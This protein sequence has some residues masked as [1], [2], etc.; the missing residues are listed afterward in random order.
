MRLDV[1]TFPQPSLLLC[2]REP[3]TPKHTRFVRPRAAQTVATV[4]SGPHCARNE[5]PRGRAPEVF[6]TRQETDLNPLGAE[7]PDDSVSGVGVDQ[8]E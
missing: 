8:T 4:A 5:D 3:Q 7:P 1:G 2:T 6:V